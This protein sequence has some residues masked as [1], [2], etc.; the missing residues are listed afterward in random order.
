[1][2]TSNPNNVSWRLLLS[3]FI[4]IAIKPHNSLLVKPQRVDT[5]LVILEIFIRVLC[6]DLE[7]V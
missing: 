5:I 7:L 2:L 4:N 6:I 3:K 1:M